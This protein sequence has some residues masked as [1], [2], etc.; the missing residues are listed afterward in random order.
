MHL[1]NL[2][3]LRRSA[4]VITT[5]SEH[6]F[7][8]H[9]NLVSRTQLSGMNG[10]KEKDQLWIADTTFARL[11]QE[12]VYFAVLLDAF[13]RRVVGWALDLCLWQLQLARFG[14]LIWPTL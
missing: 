7:E 4:F 14:R 13:S 3:F 9:V 1:D 12:F 10:K 2:L 11:Q 8:V 5:N 6:D